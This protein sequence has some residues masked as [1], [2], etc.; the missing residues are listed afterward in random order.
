MWAVPP[1][2]VLADRPVTLTPATKPA[3][4][5]AVIESDRPFV[6]AKPSYQQYIRCTAAVCGLSL[7]PYAYLFV[8]G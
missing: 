6:A 1:P 3:T 4:I 2:D 8:L 7:V 5:E